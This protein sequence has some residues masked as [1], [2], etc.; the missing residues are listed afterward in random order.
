MPIT[1]LLRFERDTGDA[2]P[3]TLVREVGCGVEVGAAFGAVGGRAGGSVGGE[4]GHVI[5][6]DSGKEVGFR[7]ACLDSRMSEDVVLKRVDRSRDF[8]R[9][10]KPKR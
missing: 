1:V 6:G 7:H 9:K 2:P 8:T 4:S 10:S 5:S 3:E